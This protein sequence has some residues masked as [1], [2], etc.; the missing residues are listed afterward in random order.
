VEVET[1]LAALA[2]SGQEDEDEIRRA[3]DAG[4]STLYPSN[5][6]RR[7]A[8]RVEADPLDRV[9]RALGRLTELSPD[10]LRGLLDAAVAT[11]RADE[12]V[13]VTEIE[14]LRAIA[15]AVGAPMPP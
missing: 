8:F 9:D 1:V 6:E 3:F 15:E 12:D 14:M 13:S 4:A 5:E 11:I 7:T 2:R 10:D